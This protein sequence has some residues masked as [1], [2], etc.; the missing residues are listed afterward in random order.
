MEAFICMS[1]LKIGNK[2]ILASASPRRKELLEDAGVDFEICVSNAEEDESAIADPS[3]VCVRNARAKAESVA[4][5]RSGRL[6]L[7]ADTVVFLGGRIYGKPRDDAD[8][9]R[10]L[11]ELQGKTHS[12]FTGVCAAYSPDGKT[13]KTLCAKEESK[14]S[15]KR[16]ARAEIE[17]YMSKVNVFDK[18]GAYAAQEHG[19]AII[20]KIDGA[21]DNVMGLP[22]GLSKK[23]LDTLGSS[24]HNRA[25]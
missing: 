3:D 18:A 10:I 13:L 5:K 24:M 7:G 17:N 11:S 2:I 15:F 16:L 8:A 14:V 23:I 25:Q 19:S 20:D 4:L 6:V 12:V 21:F 22:V 9:V 1:S